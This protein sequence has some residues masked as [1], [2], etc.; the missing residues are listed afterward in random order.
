RITIVLIACQGC[1]RRRRPAIC[2]ANG[3]GLSMGWIVLAIVVAVAVYAIVIY[4][5][6]VRLRNMVREGFSGVDVQLRRRTDLVPNLVET[7]KAYA[8]HEREVLEEVAATRA[9]S[10]AASDVHGQAAAAPALQAPLGKPC[11]PPEAHP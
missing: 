7:V 8:A 6:L 2:G 3:K 4:N 5:R 10:I 11:P 9:S 1:G